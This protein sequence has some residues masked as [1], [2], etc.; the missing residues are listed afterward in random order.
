MTEE[1]LDTSLVEA[2]RREAQQLGDDWAAGRALL[3]GRRG[4]TADPAP[5][6]M[7]DLELIVTSPLTRTLQTATAIFYKAVGN[8]AA[9]REGCRKLP[10]LALDLVKEWSQGR[11]TP[12]LRKPRSKL[13]KAYPHVDFT[14][15]TEEDTTWKATWPGEP[16]GLEPRRHLEMRVA[17][18]RKWVRERPE[19]HIVL[20][21][22]GT[23]LGN[24]LYG[25]FIEDKE[26]EHG[27]LYA[28]DLD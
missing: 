8:E 10:I 25:S 2:G 17:S 1:T 14:H 22:H 16:S 27:K 26:L 6:H 13:Q 12:N 19:E 5:W 3:Y 7:A 4:A 23:F 9:P 15:L 18:F 20:I 24:L 11:H 28:C 21:G